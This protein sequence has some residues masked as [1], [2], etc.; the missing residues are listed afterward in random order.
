MLILTETSILMSLAG[1]RQSF[2]YSVK[3][4]FLSEDSILDL[5]CIHL[6]SFIEIVSTCFCLL[7]SKK[8]TV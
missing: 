7:S 4:A 1:L 2:R 3:L 8:Q 5:L 6:V